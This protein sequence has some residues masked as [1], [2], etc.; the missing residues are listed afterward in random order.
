MHAIE[1]C[2]VCAGEGD[3][4]LSTKLLS[5]N[6]MPAQKAAKEIWVKFSKPTARNWSTNQSNHL[7]KEN[8]IDRQVEN[9]Y[10]EMINSKSGGEK[11]CYLIWQCYIFVFVRMRLYVFV[12][13]EELHFEKVDYNFNCMN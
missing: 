10:V 1:S 8:T 5:H 11:T 4:G 9:A 12:Q 2:A 6:K 7:T 13:Q 3:A